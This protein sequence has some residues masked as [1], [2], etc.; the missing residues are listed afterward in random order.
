MLTYDMLYPVADGDS[1]P[2]N[3]LAHDL[4]DAAISVAVIVFVVV[5]LWESWNLL[6][7]YWELRCVRD[8]H[9]AFRNKLVD[10]YREVIEFLASFDVSREYDD[11]SQE[12]AVTV[13]TAYKRILEEHILLLLDYRT[14]LIDIER[15]KR[16]P[17]VAHQV[18]GFMKQADLFKMHANV[19]D[20]ICKRLRHYFA[21][22]S[23]GISPDHFGS[24]V[25]EPSVKLA[26]CR[27]LD[28]QYVKCIKAHMGLLKGHPFL[29]HKVANEIVQLNETIMKSYE[30]E[31]HILEGKDEG[32]DDEGSGDSVHGNIVDPV[33]PSDSAA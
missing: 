30:Y 25:G 12:Q 1:T 22:E 4:A 15:E 28:H 26:D 17:S 21:S 31:Q 5:S 32:K 23:F 20:T 13:C 10:S 11:T 8:V 33:S 7:K 9:V 14:W 29:K 27:R 18:E 3:T 2:D 24:K 19:R 6:C 16:L